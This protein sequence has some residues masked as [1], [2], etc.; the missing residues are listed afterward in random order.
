MCTSFTHARARTH[1]Q[2]LI[3]DF[4]LGGGGGGG[5][6]ASDRILGQDFGIFVVCFGLLV[7]SCVCVLV[8]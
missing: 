7:V 1:T 8:F 2:G 3:Q 6:L 5:I 4:S